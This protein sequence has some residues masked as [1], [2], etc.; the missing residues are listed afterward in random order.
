MDHVTFMQLFAIGADRSVDQDAFT[1]VG[2]TTFT[3]PPNVYS[4]SWVGIQGGQGGASAGGDGGYLAYLNNI[5]VTPNE[6]LTLVTGAAGAGAS[7]NNSNATVK[8]SAGGHSRLL[9]GATTLASTDPADFIPGI[10]R[11]AGGLGGNA[12]LSSY[13]DG[14]GGGGAGGYAGEGGRG[15]SYSSSTLS[16]ANSGSGGA[17]GG[18]GMTMGYFLATFLYVG[19]FGGRGGGTGLNGQGSSGPAGTSLSPSAERAANA[20]ANSGGGVGSTAPGYGYGGGGGR[21]T[22]DSTNGSVTTS[23]GGNGGTGANRLIWPGTI[24][25]F[26]STRTADE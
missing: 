25:Q 12:L 15:A 8:G 19:F 23:A 20:D 16:G 18:G 26:P 5:P 14:G 22:V 6:A 3:V 9:R 2:T 13:S 7:F 17:G 1:T 24:R 11:F 21:T 10:V 4:I